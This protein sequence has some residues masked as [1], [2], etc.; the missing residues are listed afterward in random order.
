MTKERKTSPKG[1][2]GCRWLWRLR[3]CLLSFASKEGTELAGRMNE[4]KRFGMVGRLLGKNLVLGG[5]L[6]D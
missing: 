6:A 2:S 1:R 4:E 5:G 3:L